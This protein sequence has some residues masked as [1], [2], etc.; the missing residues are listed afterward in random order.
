MY[1]Y[2]TIE[3]KWQKYWQENE[4]FKTDVWDFSKPK[5]YV[6]DMFPYPSGVGLHAGHVEGYTATDI[7]SRMKRMQGY[8]VL[9]PMG[10]DS[11]GLPAEQYAVQTGNHPSGFTEKNIKYFSEQLNT[12][13]FDYDWSKMI[14]TSDPKY[15][16]WTQWIFK[17]LY[18]DGYAKYI[19]MP[20]NWCEELGTV[21]SNDE[22]IDGKSERGGYPV[23]RKK[24]KQLCIDQPKFAE[25]L[26]E[27]LNEIDWPESTKEMQRNWIGKSIG[28]HVKFKI[29]NH[30]LDFTVFTTRP[31]TLY[32]ATY[33]VLAPEHEYVDIITT[34]DKKEEVLE[35][36]KVCAS[37][38]D[39]ERTELNKD[40]T[41]VFTGAYA[42]NPVNDTKIPIYISDYVLASYGTG[43]I[44]AVPAHD[45]RD[46]EFAKKFN[47]PIIQVLAKNFIGTGSSEVRSDKPMT[48]RRVVN[49]IIK[50]PTEDKY[51]CVNNKKF[52]WIDFVMGGIEGEETSIEA[53]KR[54]IAEET[55]YTDFADLREMEFIYYD[56]F[57][58]AHK[59]V[60]RHITCYTVV[61]KL[62]SLEQI[63]ISKEEQDIA[64]IK[65]IDKENLLD[66]LTNEAHKY[67]FSLLM[68]GEG[69][70][71]D[72]GTHINSEILNGLNKEEAIN[73]MVAWLEERGLGS[74]KINYKFREW[75]FARQR[76]WGEPVP[77]VHLENG[78]DILLED[79]E[80]PLVLPELKD[81]KGHNGKA[82]LENAV[83]WKTYVTENGIK[84]VRETST[85]P[86]S[87]G[88]SWYYLRY[89]DPNND[90]EFCNQELAKHWLPVDLYMG[91][92]EH[93]VGH[94]MYSRIWNN[95][96]YDKGLSP[97]K[98]P[99]KKLVH[100]GMILGEN[101][102]KMGK[103]YPEF[104]IDPKDIAAS[105]GADTLRLYEMFMGPIE[106]SKPW[107]SKGVEGA[108]KFVDRVWRF[109]TNMENI[110]DNNDGSLDKAYHTMVKKVTDDFEKLGF[111]TAISQFMVFV[112]VCYKTM[113]CPKVYAEGFIKMLSCVT[114]HLG[115][116]IWE[117][118][119][120]KNTIAYEPWPT[121]DEEKLVD[122]EVNIAISV[123]GKLRNTIKVAL[124]SEEEVL[125]DLALKDEKVAKYL[126]GK[127][128][129]KTIIVPNKIIN[130]VV[131]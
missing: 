48:E 89:I 90:K 5:Y 39:L 37:K 87:A 127:E 101:G 29:D 113:K 22:V 33:C 21:L 81:Y 84:G 106:D 93:A 95:Y 107:S 104:A 85:M 128:I 52:N 91:G 57:Y 112:N 30:D 47:I 8:N 34:P 110:T 12:L 51:L 83:E 42:I 98:E 72:D 102:I 6:L 130:I 65:W 103:R 122:E 50:H 2:K 56:T 96:L 13:G 25:R 10:Y 3:Q 40:K 58:A 120:H 105:Y 76:Y 67:S 28:A 68:K 108:K 121:Y 78:E 75:I 99:F 23:I 35:Y 69:A 36:K 131:K 118:Y 19:D 123:N 9:H 1:D 64:D 15:Y 74:K 109:F 73:K 18:K 111:N 59:D 27:G 16:K 41:G 86:G 92:P 94:L 20:V 119:G 17:E 44:M 70:Y 129:V 54:E 7:V 24:M 4:T 115:E 66:T 31:D 63:A 38:S 117:M 49:A 80:L 82:P 114:P 43:A 126:E 45:E 60:N 26:L 53:A 77:I 125:K 79:K 116:E 14:S 11:F 61:G 55:G 100:Q 88:S 71:T 46:Y 97:V 124:N 32:G 62:K